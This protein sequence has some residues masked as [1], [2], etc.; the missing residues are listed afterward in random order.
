MSN[1]IHEI[2]FDRK[3][4]QFIA[5]KPPT[6]ITIIMHSNTICNCVRMRL[7]ILKT[8]TVVII[9]LYLCLYL[10]F[11]FVNKEEQKK[12]SDGANTFN[13]EGKKTRTVSSSHYS[14]NLIGKAC[15]FTLPSTHFKFLSCQQ[16]L[17]EHLIS[18]GNE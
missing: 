16:E 6:S 13:Y 9:V 5:W 11:I 2:G 1:M 4:S 15:V 7:A 10:K 8:W 12:L 18:A 17:T 14:N 3:F